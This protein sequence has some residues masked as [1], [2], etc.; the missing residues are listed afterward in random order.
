MLITNIQRFSIHDGEGIR[1]IAFLK[2]CTLKCSWCHNPENINGNMQIFF[3]KSKCAGCNLC[4]KTCEKLNKEFN[5]LN[6]IPEINLSCIE[7]LKCIEACPYDAIEIIGKEYSLDE[8]YSQLMRDKAFYTESNGGVT[9]SGGEPLIRAFELLPLLQR[10]K[11]NKI[12]IAI[13]TAGNVK[14]DNFEAILPFIDNA[15]EFLFDIKC[16]DENL[17]KRFTGSSNKLILEN[18]EK[19]YKTQKN[20]VARIPVIPDFNADDKNIKDIA[21][22]LKDYKNI[23]HAEFMPFH[24]IAS[25]KYV[26]MNLKNDFADYKSIDT[27]SDLIRGFKDIFK[28]YDINIK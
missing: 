28:S 15:G 20:I 4:R 25:H 16:I 22:F 12:S 8:L 23:K 11:E 14:W 21:I 9:F 6:N 2:G 10:L 26:S 27:N 24:A 7:C 3:H 1:T 19:L 18:F 17:H 13:E 5:I